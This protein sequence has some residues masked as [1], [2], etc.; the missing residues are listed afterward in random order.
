MQWHFPLKVRRYL[1][2]ILTRTAFC[3]HHAPC[4]CLWHHLLR[5]Y[6]VLCLGGQYR[7]ITPYPQKAKNS[8]EIPNIFSKLG[9]KKS[10]AIKTWPE[11]TNSL[12]WSLWCGSL[13]VWLQKSP[14][15]WWWGA[16]QTSPECVSRCIH[17]VVLFLN[18]ERFLIPKHICPKGY[19]EDSRL[20][21]LSLLSKNWMLRKVKSPGKNTS[22]KRETN[23]GLQE[24]E[25]RLLPLILLCYYMKCKYYMKTFKVFLTLE[26]QR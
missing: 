9:Q 3:H 13:N 26:F 23:T 4:H 11:A 7:S 16:A 6:S 12:Y 8:S 21:L 14:C 22:L 15:A 20:L 5:D 1:F 19:K 17:T 10:L 18:S 24:S 2:Q 25:H